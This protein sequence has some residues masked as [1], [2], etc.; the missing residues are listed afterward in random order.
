MSKIEFNT[1]CYP[2]L[3]NFFYCKVPMMVD[4]KKY[5]TSE[6]LYQAMKFAY[7][8][9]TVSG[10]SLNACKELIEEIRLQGTP[11]KAK[12]LASPRG[13][14]RYAWQRTLV[15]RRED[16]A[17]RG[18]LL[19]QRWDGVKVDV[20]EDVL[21]LK[22]WSDAAC[23]GVLMGTEDAELVERTDTDAF[24]GDGFDGK[25]QNMLGKLLMRIRD[26]WRRDGVPKNTP[27]LR[28][29]SVG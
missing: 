28:R 1:N 8:L 12:T 5:S 10:E 17:A 16:F 13:F 7:F 14:G 3:S 29:S 18:V 4:G 26:E 6:H 22:F 23:R 9:P 27:I 15:K 2:Q 11:Y 19:D 20:M 25:G 21:R 24:W